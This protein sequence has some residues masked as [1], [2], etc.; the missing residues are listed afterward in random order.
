MQNLERPS[1]DK[2]EELVGRTFV[3]LEGRI[4]VTGITNWSPEYVDV[5]LS[6]GTPSVR[7]AEHVRNALRRKAA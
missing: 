3:S 5:L 6:D 1:D 2:R 4:T 7:S